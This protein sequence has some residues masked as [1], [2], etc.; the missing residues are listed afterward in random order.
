MINFFKGL[1]LVFKNKNTVAETLWKT[2]GTPI[3]IARTH[4]KYK[5]TGTF[6]VPF[7]QDEYLTGYFSGYINFMLINCFKITNQTDRGDVMSKIYTAFDP[8]F[9]ASAENFTKVMEMIT[10]RHGKKN[11]TDFVKI[12]NVISASKL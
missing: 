7:M 1:G 3:G 12:S 10:R 11:T 9:F 8:I 4:G 5:Q 2:I 6:T